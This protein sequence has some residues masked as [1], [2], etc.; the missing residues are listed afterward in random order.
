M[1]VPPQHL[2]AQST[3]T[4]GPGSVLPQT[5]LMKVWQGWKSSG[6]VGFDRVAVRN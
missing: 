3:D 1:S 5:I 4:A 6:C 2:A